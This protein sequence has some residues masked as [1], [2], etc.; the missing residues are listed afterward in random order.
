MKRTSAPIRIM[1]KYCITLLGEMT[2]KYRPYIY[3]SIFNIDDVIIFNPNTT[4][5]MTRP[6]IFLLGVL[7]KKKENG[8]EKYFKVRKNEKKKSEI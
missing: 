3:Y 4:Y 8:K 1:P 2:I 5:G 7:L 6:W